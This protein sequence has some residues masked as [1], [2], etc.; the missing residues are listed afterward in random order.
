MTQ[1]KPSTC[2]QQC[3]TTHRKDDTFCGF[4]KGF[5]LAPQNKNTKHSETNA[6]KGKQKCDITEIKPKKDYKKDESLAMPEV[7][8][9]LNASQ[10]FLH[11]KGKLHFVWTE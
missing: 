5:L 7:Q 4:K 11:N 9:A 1:E 6:T 10:A 8:Q 2:I 3:R